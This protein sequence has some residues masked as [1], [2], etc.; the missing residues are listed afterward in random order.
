MPAS[1]GRPCLLAG[2]AGVRG[3]SRTTARR[4]GPRAGSTSDRRC[5]PGPWRRGSSERSSSGAKKRSRGTLSST[6]T[7]SE[8]IQTCR[9]ISSSA[10]SCGLTARVTSSLVSSATAS[11]RSGDG[12]ST[13]R[14]QWRAARGAWGSRCSEAIRSGCCGSI[15][16]LPDLPG[17]ELRQTPAGRRPTR[18]RGARNAVR[19]VSGAGSARDPRGRGSGPPRS[20]RSHHEARGAAGGRRSR[21]QLLPPGR[22]HGR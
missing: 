17:A 12:E 7:M 2:A 20:I 15:G 8:G 14:T 9:R 10:A 6:L 3:R 16:T 21:L 11:R 13:R 1:A 4:C 18:D 22:V 5:G 19:A